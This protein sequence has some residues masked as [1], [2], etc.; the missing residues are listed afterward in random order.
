ML[1]I[2]WQKKILSY[3]LPLWF[4]L[5][6]FFII[7]SVI[8]PVL[9]FYNL[10]ETRKVC[11]VKQTNYLNFDLS[12][13][14]ITKINK[15]SDI[16]TAIGLKKRRSI[17]YRMFNIVNKKGIKLDF[18]E[19]NLFALELQEIY[20]SKAEEIKQKGLCDKI[21]T[22]ARYDINIFSSPRISFDNSRPLK[23]TIAEE[24]GVNNFFCGISISNLESRSNSHIYEISNFY[25]MHIDEL[26]P[27]GEFLGVYIPYS[28]LGGSLMGVRDIKLRSEKALETISIDIG[29]KMFY[30]DILNQISERILN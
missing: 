30:T 9:A 3:S 29:C 10:N 1:Y 17:S 20:L 13:L 2:A 21:I 18:K 19:D 23:D 22:S 5:N 26:Y 14:E 24:L 4:I 12:I 8:N 15:D 25:T 28:T 27:N 11:F 6:L 7:I 16:Y